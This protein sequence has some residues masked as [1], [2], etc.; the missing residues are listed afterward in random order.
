MN[1]PVNEAVTALKYTLASDK[2]IAHTRCR[3]NFDT[4]NLTQSWTKT[5]E[6]SKTKMQTKTS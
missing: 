2:L 6:I 3:M 4:Q 1:A 5:F